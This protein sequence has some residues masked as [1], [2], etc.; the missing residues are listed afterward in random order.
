M[1]VSI[2]KSKSNNITTNKLEKQLSDK[3][4]Q[5]ISADVD[6]DTSSKA[7]DKKSSEKAEYSSPVHSS[8]NSVP[9]KAIVS[10][11]GSPGS[12]SVVLAKSNSNS[13]L[14]RTSSDRTASASNGQT[15]EKMLSATSSVRS[16]TE[17]KIVTSVTVDF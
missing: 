7:Q 8:S 10:P 15:A 17:E 9:D 6:K 13:K 5:N 3:K 14:T 12:G 2:N 4:P 11:T 1:N 16:A